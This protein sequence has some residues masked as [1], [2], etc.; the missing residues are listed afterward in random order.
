MLLYLMFVA[1]AAEIVYLDGFCISCL[2]IKERIWVF[3]F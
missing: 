3:S 2:A 1:L